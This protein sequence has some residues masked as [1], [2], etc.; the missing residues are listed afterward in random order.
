VHRPRSC[1]SVV[2]SRAAAPASRPRGKGASGTR[3]YTRQP[4]EGQTRTASHY[5]G[6]LPGLRRH[7]PIPCYFWARDPAPPSLPLLPRT[8]PEPCGKGSLVPSDARGYDAHQAPAIR[9]PEPFSWTKRP[10]LPILGVVSRSVGPFPWRCA[11]VVV[12]QVPAPAVS[13]IA[14]R[15]PAASRTGPTPAS[16][17]ARLRRRTSLPRLGR[18]KL[19]TQP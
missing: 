14:R 10:P 11:T 4:R 2:A 12:G 6:T 7:R 1:G 15:A 13:R 5:T 18:R 16:F 3:G 8:G 19:L 9:F 17:R